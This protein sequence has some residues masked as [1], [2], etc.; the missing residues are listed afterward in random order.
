[1]DFYEYSLHL[2]RIQN[3]IDNIQTNNEVK[4]DVYSKS[5]FIDASDLS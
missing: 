5:N 3:N 2:K 1:M 4:V